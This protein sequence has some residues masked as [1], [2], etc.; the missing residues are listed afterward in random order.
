MKLVKTL[1]LTALL[2]L[3][4]T[5]VMAQK[6]GDLAR[7]YCKLHSCEDI[8]VI[9]DIIKTPLQGTCLIISS[10]TLSR[11]FRA[12]YSTS[13]WW[14]LISGSLS[15]KGFDQAIK[16]AKK[17]SRST[18]KQVFLAEPV[19]GEIGQAK[20]DYCTASFDLSKRASPIGILLP[21]L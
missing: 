1:Y 3:P 7:K 14:L 6:S 15:A 19:K 10:E 2:S 5:T 21:K 13:N 20:T 11:N 8:N 16:V 9:E 12:G 17:F 18:H 4:P